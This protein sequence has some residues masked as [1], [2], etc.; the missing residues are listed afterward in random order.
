M[1]VDPSYTIPEFCNAER[2]SVSMLYKMWSQGQGP[3]YF[4]V[5]SSRRIS[6][7]ARIEWRTEREAAAAASNG[8]AAA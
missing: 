3:R 7:E 8:A 1:T 2:L 4:L 6:H 5:G